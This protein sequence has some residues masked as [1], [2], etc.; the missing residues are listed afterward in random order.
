MMHKRVAWIGSAILHVAIFMLCGIGG[1]R[2]ATDVTVMVSS[3]GNP[4]PGAEITLSLPG[5]ENKLAK[6]DD[7]DGRIAFVLPG[8]GTYKGR[9]RLPDGSERPIVLR[10]G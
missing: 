1:V 8:R 2:A 9:L 3:N 4:L 6:D 10:L 5:G 7:H